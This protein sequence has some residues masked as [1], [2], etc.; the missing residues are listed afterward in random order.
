MRYI[1]LSSILNQM[2]DI[3]IKKKMM[4]GMVVHTYN[5]SIWK[6]EAGGSKWNLSG[7]QCDSISKQKETNKT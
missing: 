1:R 5:T 3:L 2:A 6:V 4:L 7:L